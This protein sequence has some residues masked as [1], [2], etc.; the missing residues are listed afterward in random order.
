MKFAVA[1]MDF[2]ENDLKIKIV[3]ADDW[4]EALVKAFEASFEGETLKEARVAAF[5]QDYLFNVVEL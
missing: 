3:E 1:F 4:R 2:F 5:N